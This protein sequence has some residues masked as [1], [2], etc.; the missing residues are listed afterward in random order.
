MKIERII[1]GVDGSENSR[2]AL[3]WSA[4]LAQALDAEVI[5]VH[6]VGLLERMIEGTEHVEGTYSDARHKFDTEWCAALEQPGLRST[7]L[8]R[9]GNPVSVLLAAADDYDA[10]LIVVGS[11]GVGGYPELL[12]GST[13]T[14]L[15]QL[16]MRPVTVIPSAFVDERA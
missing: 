9:D 14:Q 6:S 2:R 12:L 10:H 11:R 7:R 8:M 13:S 4:D 3:Q 16:S 5:A 1:V 15:A